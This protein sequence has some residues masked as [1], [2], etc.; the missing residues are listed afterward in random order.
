M[1]SD[2]DF[3]SNFWSHSYSQYKYR[4]DLSDADSISQKSFDDMKEGTNTKY[5]TR[6]KLKGRGMLVVTSLE[7]AEMD[8]ARSWKRALEHRIRLRESALRGSATGK[9][10]EKPDGGENSERE[11]T[12]PAGRSEGYR[13]LLAHFEKLTSRKRSRSASSSSYGSVRSNWTSWSDSESESDSDPDKPPEFPSD[14][15]CWIQ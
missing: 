7:A 12:Q 8:R 1:D 11:Y 10:P 3:Q 13:A 4:H 14:F 9:G 2:S 15:D 6:R 5:S